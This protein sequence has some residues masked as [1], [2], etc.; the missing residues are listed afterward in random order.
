MDGFLSLI[1]IYRVFISCIH[2]SSENICSISGGAQE[3]GKRGS[4]PNETQFGTKKM[5]HFKVSAPLKVNVFF[6]RF[7]FNLT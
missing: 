2:K 6:C 3:K 4:K 7:F 1:F 5:V